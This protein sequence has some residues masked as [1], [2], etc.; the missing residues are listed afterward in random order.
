MEYKLTSWRGIHKFS[1]SRWLYRGQRDVTW[2][3]KTSLDR[4]CDREGV[5]SNDRVEFEKSLIREFR[6]AYHHYDSRNPNPDNNLEWL[7][8]MQHYGAPTRLLD[9][10]YSL[11][12]AAAFAVEGAEKDC[13]VWAFNR[14][15]VLNEAKSLSIKKIGD[16]SLWEKF[17]D[18]FF[19]EERE[20]VIH[21][22]FFTGPEKPL[23]CLVN[24]FHMNQRLKIQQG[25]FLM[26]GAVNIPFMDNLKALR[27]YDNP[28]NVKKI[29]IPLNVRRDVQKGLFSMNLSQATLFPGLDG[30]ARSLG[31]F[32]PLLE[33]EHYYRRR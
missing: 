1:N 12:V 3:L 29:I 2:D 4:C 6:R 20:E 7:S 5:R 9:F 33:P 30:F 22:I 17:V 24:P 11:Y 14:R 10:T 28:K 31:E 23:V 13:V 8:L 16:P 26:Q 18:P 25:I 19:T 32:L 21:E 27:G 15:W